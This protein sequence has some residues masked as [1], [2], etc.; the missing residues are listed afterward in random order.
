M[1]KTALHRELRELAPK[2]EMIPADRRM[3]EYK[4][5]T[6]RLVREDDAASHIDVMMLIYDWESGE[7]LMGDHRKSGLWLVNG[8]HVEKEENLAEAVMRELEEEM[9]WKINQEK[10]GQPEFLTVCAIE[11]NGYDCRRH[12][13]IWFLIPV[14]KGEL[15]IDEEKM[16]TEFKEWGWFDMGTARKLKTSN[17]HFRV[18]DY[19]EKKLKE[20]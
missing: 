20:G 17:N 16:R 13:D 2:L 5:G 7:V 19:L 8:G 1:T 6:S 4:L 15:K 14:E 12:Y 3:F 18:F 10:V 9:G 11:A